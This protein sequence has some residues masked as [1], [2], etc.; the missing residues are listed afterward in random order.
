MSRSISTMG[1]ALLALPRRCQGQGEKLPKASQTIQVHLFAP[2][3]RYWDTSLPTVSIQP[4]TSGEPP[5]EYSR[6]D[7]QLVYDIYLRMTS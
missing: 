4:A 1:H 6:E 7:I 2:V 5:K 3:M